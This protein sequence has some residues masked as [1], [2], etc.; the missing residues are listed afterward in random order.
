MTGQSGDEMT[1]WRAMLEA[2][3]FEERVAALEAVVER[4]EAGNV[5]I[6]ES[7]ALYELGIGLA[8]S[9]TATIDAAELRVEELSRQ[10]SLSDRQTRIMQYSL[11]GEDVPDDDP[12][13][14]GPF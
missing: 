1:V 12:S 14:D 13:D 10:S 11:L 9:A 7:I 4:L 2:G 6:D 8:T 5:S 3:S